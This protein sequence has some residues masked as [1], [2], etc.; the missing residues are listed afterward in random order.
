M[1]RPLLGI[2]RAVAYRRVIAGKVL[3]IFTCVVKIEMNFEKSS[4]TNSVLQQ[5][6]V[7]YC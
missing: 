6:A 5:F 1:L 4:T 7:E 3:L 2:F